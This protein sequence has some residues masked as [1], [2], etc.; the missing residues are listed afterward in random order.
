MIRLTAEIYANGNNYIIA[1]NLTKL[2]FSGQDR[3]DTTLPSWGIK[4]NSGSLE[5][6]DTDEIIE[7]LSNQGLLA[8]SEIKIYLNVKSRKK[9]IGG[10]Y[11]TDASKD[12]HTAKTKIGF[13][14]ELMSWNQKQMPIY[15]YLYYPRE[16]SAYDILTYIIQKAG[17]V[18]EYATQET[19]N[20]LKS[21]YIAYP[22]IEKGSLWAQTA[23]I[24]ELSCCYIYCNNNGT[25]TI[26]YGGGA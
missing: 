3:S 11:I 26:H 20:I 22:I 12:K 16:I 2:S 15:L 18:L 5:M 1:D 6:Y 13:Q 23:K 9:Q 24:C 10:F 19:I 7:R 21:I 8:N 4:S 25:P 17:V 14:D